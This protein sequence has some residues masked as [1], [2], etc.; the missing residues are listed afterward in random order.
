MAEK[1]SFID[2]L[3]TYIESDKVQLPV[4]NATALRIREELAKKEPDIKIIEKV[5]L[6]DQSLSSQILKIA[7]SS[8]YRGMTEISSIRGA[9]MRLGTK[10]IGR[11]VL[12]ASTQNTFKSREKSSQIIMKRLW[13]H[14]V[15]CAYGAV[16]INKRHEYNIPSEQVF[17]AALFHDV[18]KLFILM[19]IEQIKKKNPRMQITPSLLKEAMKKLHSAEGF[20]LLQHWNVPEQFAVVARDHHNLEFSQDNILLVIVRMANMVCNN[21]GISVYQN[22]PVMLPATLEANILNLSEIDLAELEIYLEDS[23][24]LTS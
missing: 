2:I 10:E 15:G 5:I 12:I 21:L 8:F 13:Q 20:K 19:V 9:I 18:G 24:A 3:N 17:F 1:S 16:W 6:A 23:K 4:F 11:V 22:E 7:N 14:S